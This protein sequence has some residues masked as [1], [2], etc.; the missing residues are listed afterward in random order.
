M[1]KKNRNLLL[2]VAALMLMVAVLLLSNNQAY[3]SEIIS[4]KLHTSTVRDISLNQKTSQIISVT[5]IP[6]V[7][8]DDYFYEALRKIIENYKVDVTLPDG[9]FRGNQFATRGQFIQWLRDGLDRSLEVIASVDGEPILLVDNL[10][11]ITAAMVE[12]NLALGLSFEEE[13]SQIKVRLEEL[14]S[15][16]ISNKRLTANSKFK[17]QN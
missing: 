12:D 2:V 14:E 4:D 17:I 8:P 16:A 15:K 9:N 6:D 11:E 3:T 10:E 7:S 13:L 1:V 5:E